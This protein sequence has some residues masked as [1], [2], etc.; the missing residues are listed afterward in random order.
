[1][2]AARVLV[3]FAAW[4]P[5]VAF[6]GDRIASV[7]A[8]DG[9]EAYAPRA[10][11]APTFDVASVDGAPQLVIRSEGREGTDG[12]WQKT[13]PVTEGAWLRFSAWRKLDNA[14]SPRR[15]APVRIVWHD[16]KGKPVFWHEPPVNEYRAGPKATAQPDHPIDGKTDKQGWTEV[17][18][19]YCVPERATRAT[20]ELHLRWEPQGTIT[21]RDIAFTPSQPPKGRKVRLAA[22]HYRAK[23]GHTAMDNYKQFEP[24]IA[25]AA[26]QRA[27]LVCLGEMIN[28]DNNDFKNRI[29]EGAEPIPGPGTE[30]FGALAK[31]HDM[32]IVAGLYERAAPL[33]YNVAVLLGP[34]G[35]LVGKYRKC[36]L[37]KGE[38]E[39]GV[40]PGHEYPV[41]ETR[42]GKVGMMVC[43][44]AFFP[45]V[46]RHLA[47]H[48]AEVI[49]LP[50]AGC[51]PKLAAARAIENHIYLV[52]STY[53][54]ASRNWIRS[55]VY[56]H[57]GQMLV[58][59]EDWGTVVT[60]EVD[61]DKTTYWHSLGDFKSRLPRESPLWGE[62][63]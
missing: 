33:V 6:G 51:N 47:H 60:A 55:A 29:A 44:D 32:Y 4:M 15:A 23:G 41:F 1:M 63:E 56:D 16:D 50:V 24:L 18:G 42:F 58:A 7:E 20:V 3:V 2:Y 13:F 45:E 46:A 10:E 59:A 43:Y 54:D 61:L 28:V 36:T 31:K 11:I 57:V 38:L 52:S 9:W 5:M 21:W 12:Y 14:E 62:N 48:G 26:R 53:T 37:P 19:L 39:K 17:T 8:V 30:Y 22:V 35:S 34:D 27:D 40:A 25:E 49:A